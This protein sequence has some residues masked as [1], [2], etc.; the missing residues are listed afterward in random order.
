MRLNLSPRSLLWA[1][2]IVCAIL[3]APH[4]AAKGKGLVYDKEPA[5][6]PFQTWHC[7]MAGADGQVFLRRTL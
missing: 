3:V 5:A 7:G 6:W 2:V 4:V 1:I